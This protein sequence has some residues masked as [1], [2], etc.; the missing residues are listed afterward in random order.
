MV[1]AFGLADET[2]P[3][4]MTIAASALRGVHLT[5]LRTDGLGKA[6]LEPNKIMLG[7]G[8]TLPIVL[9]PANEMGGLAITEGIEDA[10]SIHT[11]TGLGVWAAGSASRLPG[12]S[13]HVPGSVACVTV[14]IDADPAGERFGSV[15]V[16]RLEARGFEVIAKH[17]AEAGH[18]S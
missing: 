9:A 12:L 6:D 8:H 2:D 3:N 17:W 14:L 15:L 11:A 1:A 16:K 13:D 7:R 5:K 18:G 10:L 4:A